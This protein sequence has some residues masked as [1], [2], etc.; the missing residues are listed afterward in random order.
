MVLKTGPKIENIQCIQ[1][2]PISLDRRLV[3]KLI[4]NASY[5]ILRDSAYACASADGV[6]LYLFG[7]LASTVFEGVGG[8]LVSDEL[9]CD[10]AKR[11]KPRSYVFSY[12]K[13]P[14]KCVF[15]YK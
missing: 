11:R 13:L 7:E 12:R 3:S 2:V 1:D 9:L 4:S 14:I 15:C 6:S 8:E 5:E 10:V